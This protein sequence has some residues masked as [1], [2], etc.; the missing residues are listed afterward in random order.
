[1]ARIKPIDSMMR[2][3]NKFIHNFG[4]YC[5]SLLKYRHMMVGLVKK[6]FKGKFRS[7]MLGYL[8][9]IISPLLMI[10]VYLIIFSYVFGRGIPNY[11]AYMTTGM[12]VFTFVSSC[13]NG[14]STTITGNSGMITKMSFP[15]EILVFARVISNFITLIISYSILTLMLA[16]F[17]VN[18][19]W[20]Y[21]WVPVLFII[22][23]FFATGLALILSSLNVYYRD[24]SQLVGIMMMPLMFA[25][26][27]CYM[28]SQ[29]G[30]GIIEML[31]GIN[32][33]MYFIDCFHS[34]AYFGIGPDV[35]YLL[36]CMSLAAIFFIVGLI[37]F[38]KL[39][40]GFAE[41]L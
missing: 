17:D 23:F 25:T 11:W 10:I 37:T 26:P 24:I 32:P 3:D 41:K 18:F 19:G 12:F 22:V 16:L 4:H 34:V 33:L 7:S 8:W 5:A 20:N 6:E 30:S 31:W 39:E 2:S 9:H 29:M 27:I 21:L 38:R 40:T 13:M 14:G 15:Y 36:I 28:K 1:M 35:T